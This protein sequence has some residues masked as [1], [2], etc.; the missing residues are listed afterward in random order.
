[1]RLILWLGGN[2]V[3][4]FRS[5]NSRL[6]RINTAPTSM[7]LTLHFSSMF[8][9]QAQ[10]NLRSVTRTWIG[11]QQ[12]LQGQ[13]ATAMSISVNVALSLWTNVILT[14]VTNR[15]LCRPFL[16]PVCLLLFCFCFCFAVDIFRR[17]NLN[18]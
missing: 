18:I 14:L 1:M 6:T 9:G 15:L 3:R 4:V 2:C 12:S 16:L 13:Q 7:G 17:I 11:M 10:A 5:V 8:P